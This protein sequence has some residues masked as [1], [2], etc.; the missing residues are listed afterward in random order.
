M[1]CFPP[2]RCQC[3]VKG[4]YQSFTKSKG[5][6]VRSPFVCARPLL[7]FVGCPSKWCSVCAPV[8]GN[9]LGFVR[10]RRVLE[11]RLDGAR[12]PRRLCPALLL[13]FIHPGRHCVDHV[14]C[15]FLGRFPLGLFDRTLFAVALVA[16]DYFYRGFLCHVLITFFPCVRLGY[17]FN[18]FPLWEFLLCSLERRRA[19]ILANAR[20]QFF[21]SLAEATP[22]PLSSPHNLFRR[23]IGRLG[24]IIFPKGAGSAG[25]SRTHQS[26]LQ[27]VHWNMSACLISDR[28]I[29]LPACF[30]ECQT[31]RRAPALCQ[32][33]AEAGRTR[34]THSHSKNRTIA[35]GNRS[36]LPN[37]SPTRRL[38]YA[39]PRSLPPCV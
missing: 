33:L 9:F 22:R 18:E 34:A 11:Q 30:A 10:L 32:A 13:E 39:L 23:R 28:R 38:A 20:P 7:E 16:L 26:W 24:P 6:P 17:S 5:D 27:C 4:L 25:V 19:T 15:R 14:T 3:F 31:A 2:R 36:L 35:G 37:H 1:L 12:R 29:K 8:V 21:K